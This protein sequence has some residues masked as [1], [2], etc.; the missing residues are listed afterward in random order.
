MHHL[1][2][3]IPTA[4]AY[5]RIASKEVMINYSNTFTK[6]YKIKH[7][8]ANFGPV[9]LFQTCPTQMAE[10]TSGAG[11]KLGHNLPEVVAIKMRVNLRCRD[12]LVAEHFLHR[13]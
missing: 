4:S 2:D 6:K 1:A 7:P 11:V 5:I 13:P 12:G 3:R 9:I 8:R 10:F